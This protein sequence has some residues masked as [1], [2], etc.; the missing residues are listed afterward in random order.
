MFW[1][2]TILLCFALTSASAQRMSYTPKDALAVNNKKITLSLESSIQEYKQALE[3]KDSQVVKVEKL[4][5]KVRG[6]NETWEQRKRRFEHQLKVIL[7][8][9]QYARYKSLQ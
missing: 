9:K 5:K 2:T 4:L 7:S 8:E 6:T 3:L 1:I